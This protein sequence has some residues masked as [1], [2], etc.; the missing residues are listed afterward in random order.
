MK[1]NLPDLKP[2]L[3][4][5][6]EGFDLRFRDPLLPIYFSCTIV[7]YVKAKDFEL[8]FKHD[9][10]HMLALFLAMTFIGQNR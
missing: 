7:I 5:D 6:R 9:L 8:E 2:V 3:K 1:N 4:L 10:Q